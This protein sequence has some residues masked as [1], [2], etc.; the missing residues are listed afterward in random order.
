M[1]GDSRHI[2]IQSITYRR[3]T[4]HR[5]EAEASKHSLCTEVR[6]AEHQTKRALRQRLFDTDILSHIGMIYSAVQATI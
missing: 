1:K 2:P 3:Q 6:A 5:H 4:I